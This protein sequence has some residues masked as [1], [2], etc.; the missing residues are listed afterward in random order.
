VRLTPS[1]KI[2]IIPALLVAGALGLQALAQQRAPLPP[3]DFLPNCMKLIEQKRYAEA[4]SL[5]EPVLAEHPDW[6]RAKFY[7][8]LTYHK[9]NRYGAARELY[10]RVL[11]LDPQYHSVR[12]FYGW[13]LYYLGEL[14]PAR[15]MFEAFLAAKPDYPD[16]IFALGLIDFDSDEI[17]S[18]RARFLEAIELA[19]QKGDTRTEAKS[20]ARLADLL[21]RTGK[22][23]AAR[24]ELERSI[25]LNPRNYEAHF[26]LSR[27]LDRLGDSAGAAAA[28]ARHQQM[29]ER[30]HPGAGGG[31]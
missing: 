13:C 19:E 2:V 5:L 22:L 9:E 4:R 24:A 30:A 14:G 10:E 17:E 27:V 23:A 28:R 18:A 20:R 16:A 8:A 21:V 1:N 12:L 3:A 11:E 31:P 25:E 29:L 6:P 15:A 26:K 7:L